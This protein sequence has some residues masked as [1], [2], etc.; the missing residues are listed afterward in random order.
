MQ[1][2]HFISNFFFEILQKHWKL[3]SLEFGNALRI[4]DHG[5][6]KSKYH[7]VGNFQAEKR[8]KNQIHHLLL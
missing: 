5:H 7:F 3:A 4:L 1:K 2:I 6:Q 8:K